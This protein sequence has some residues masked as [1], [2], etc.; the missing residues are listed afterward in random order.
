[1]ILGLVLVCGAGFG[2]LGFFVGYG[3]AK[4]GSAQREL[5]AYREGL[6]AQPHD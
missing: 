4:A 3:L 6:E 2:L 5:D 1:M